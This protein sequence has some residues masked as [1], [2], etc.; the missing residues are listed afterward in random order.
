MTTENAISIAESLGGLVEV[1][2]EDNSKPTSEE[3][4]ENSSVNPH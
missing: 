1:D 2:N 3:I 4:F